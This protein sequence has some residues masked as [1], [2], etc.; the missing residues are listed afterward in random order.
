MNNINSLN[1]KDS[2]HFP[3]ISDFI[4]NKRRSTEKTSPELKFGAHQKAKKW[5]KH[6]ASTPVAVYDWTYKNMASTWSCYVMAG[7]MNHKNTFNRD[8][9][10]MSNNYYFYYRNARLIS[11]GASSKTWCREKG[12]MS[13]VDGRLCWEKAGESGDFRFEK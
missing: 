3:C 7:I 12:E 1:H 13:W 2:S 5:K 11:A 10:S 4:S 8:R 6:E 9:S